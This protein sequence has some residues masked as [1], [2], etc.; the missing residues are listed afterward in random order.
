MIKLIDGYGIKVSSG[1]YTIG[2]QSMRTNKKTGEQT[3]CF[4]EMG[5]YTT[6]QSALKGVRKHLHRDILDKFD[7]TLAEA[8]QIINE[9]ETRFNSMLEGIDF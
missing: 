2:K 3:E 5:Y 9:M 6:V 8:I 1:C 4:T 7:G